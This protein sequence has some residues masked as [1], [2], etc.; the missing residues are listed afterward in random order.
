MSRRQFLLSL[1]TSCGTHLSS[2]WTFPI[3]RKRTEMACWVTPSCSANYFSVCA[4]FISSNACN[5][6]NLSI[7][8]GR[9]AVRLRGSSSKL[10]SP[11]RNFWYHL[12]YVVWL[13]AFSRYV[14]QI[15]S[16]ASA[17]FFFRWNAKWMK[18]RICFFVIAIVNTTDFWGY[19]YQTPSRSILEG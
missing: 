17:A 8:W 11:W 19:M 10:K 15:I 7:F 16:M 4:E 12:L 14:A 5:S 13:I 1:D 3:V 18:N 6:F 2:F 9:S